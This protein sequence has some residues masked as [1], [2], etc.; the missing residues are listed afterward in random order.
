MWGKMLVT[1]QGQRG[2]RGVGVW[3]PDLYLSMDHHLQSA[4]SSLTTMSCD[5]F[6]R[7]KRRSKRPKVDDPGRGMSGAKW[8][9]WVQ[10][11]VAEVGCAVVP[12]LLWLPRWHAGLAAGRTL[13]D[14]ACVRHPAHMCT[15]LAQRPSQPETRRSCRAFCRGTD[16]NSG[17][18]AAVD[19]AR[20]RRATGMRG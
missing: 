13:P 9:K 1:R 4:I 2:R 20:R 5:R 11:R 18:M 16:R 17:P 7:R 10:D 15:A 3:S 6:K 19:G 8:S 14:R 12:V